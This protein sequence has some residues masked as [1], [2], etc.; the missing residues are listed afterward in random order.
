MD[1]LCSNCHCKKCLIRSE[2]RR[3]FS[4]HSVYT[5]YYLTSCFSEETDVILNRLLK[6][7][8]DIGNVFLDSIGTEN[9]DKLVKIL[10]DH[11]NLAGKSILNVYQHQDIPLEEIR[12]NCSE[13]GDFLSTLSNKYDKVSIST[14]F[15]HHTM[16]V[17]Q[18]TRFRIERDWNNEINLFDSYYRHM[19][20][21]S[22]MLAGPF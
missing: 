16:F 8:S 14:E 5:Y 4:E 9:R 12:K 3:V 22:D 15:L 2:L 7:A 19:M 6:T 21:F 17:V 13:L 11:I 1:Q 20:K 18:L 10:V